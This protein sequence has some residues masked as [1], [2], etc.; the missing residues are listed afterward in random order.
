MYFR[1]KQILNYMKNLY[2]LIVAL[3]SVTLVSAQSQIDLPITWD[4]TANVN[5]AVGDFGGNVSTAGV[6]PSNSS[7][8]I[9]S[10]EKQNTAQTWAGTT[11]SNPSAP[12]GFATAIPFASG[13]TI[14]R[15]LV[16]SPDSGITVRLKCEDKTNNTISVETDAMTTV[17]NAWDT[18]E[19]DFSNQAT[20]TAAIN[21]S[22]TYDMANI[23]FNF[24]VDGATAGTKTYLLDDVWFVG[25]GSSGPSKAQIGLPIA[26]DDTANVDYTVI[27]FGGNAAMVTVD[28]T[29]SSNLL[30]Q[31]DKT[32]SAATWAGTT[33]GNT[34]LD[35]AIP[36]SANANTMK[37]RFWSPDSGIVV[38][39]KAEDHTN[40]TISVETDAMTTMNSG[41]D[42]LL[43]DFSNE[44]TGTAAI[45][46]S[47]TYD[48]L[49]IFA[50]FGVDGA[51]AGAKTYYVDDVWFDGAQGPPPPTAK[52]ITFKVDMSEY[53]GTYS[54]VF[55]NGTFNGWCGSCN[56][57]TDA[58]ND[59]VY[60]VT[61]NLAVDSF[62]FKFTT[63]GWTDQENFVGGEACTKTSG[64]STNRFEIVTGNTVLPE[65]CWNSCSACSGTPPTGND[66][67]FK[68]DMADY[69]GTYDTVYV[70]GT[71]NGWCG[72]CNPMTDANNDDVWELTINL[73]DSSFEF[74]YTV[75][76]WS[77]EEKFS[78]GES[79]TK[80][81]GGFTNRYLAPVG[82]TVLPV[83]CWASCAACTGTPTSGQVTFTLDLTSYPD[84]FTTAYVNGTFNNWC[85]TCNPM[86]DADND[87]IWDLT[88]I[89]P[90]GDTIDFKYT[91]NGWD[92]EET[93]TPG[94][95]C[96]ET[97]GGFTNR[98]LIIAGD[99]SLPQTCWEECVACSVVGIE[100]AFV[101]SRFEV[102]P[103]PSTGVFH[104]GLEFENIESVEMNIYNIAGQKLQSTQFESNRIE[105]DFDLS[106]FEG[107]VYFLELRNSQS[108]L[109]KK[110]ILSK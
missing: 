57:M 81:T 92:F 58:N 41:W 91:L 77:D 93:L 35:T 76:G 50:N 44:A 68:V 110:L 26:W 64:G 67:T 1:R 90:F 48:K 54:G 53:T 86:S 23:F 70:N 108:S 19:F 85:G 10:V 94:L 34:A 73:P 14:M 80:T 37:V 72:A 25:G 79:C 8:L 88:I 74:K 51:T 71:F 100:D 87:S 101:A 36:F 55:V 49:N 4:D 29:N 65:V 5:Y 106:Q 38:R 62:E 78:G 59:D 103:N 45:N 15:A 33:L 52:D 42:T 28:P 82:D 39:L 2:S 84:T 20:G 89:L 7:N 40:N 97:V 83:L 105:H 18:L 63:D 95:G 11:L 32:G 17:A 46:Y 99:T 30:L 56:P 69:S 43:F 24:G 22:S 104:L 9:L 6:D 31:L 47:N 66:I 3:L 96:T 102:I 60:E 98:R 12:L 107:G 75:D 21:F 109:L 27:D 61:L 16:Y 13:S